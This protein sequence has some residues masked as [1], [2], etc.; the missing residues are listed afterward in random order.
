[1]FRLN[2]DNF[3]GEHKVRAF[4]SERFLP[5]IIEEAQ[6]GIKRSLRKASQKRWKSVSQLSQLSQLSKSVKSVTGP[7]L[8]VGQFRPTTRLPTSKRSTSCRDLEQRRVEA[9]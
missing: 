1:M 3:K 8:K 6:K 9:A 7:P 5:F 2:F 4:R